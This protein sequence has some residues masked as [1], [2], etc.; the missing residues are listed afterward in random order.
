MSCPATFTRENFSC[1]PILITWLQFSTFLNGIFIGG[2]FADFQQTIPGA[3]LS[4]ASRSTHLHVKFSNAIKN[5]CWISPNK[6]TS[7]SQTTQELDILYPVRR[8]SNT[9]FIYEIPR[10]LIHNLNTLSSL[11]TCG[12]SAFASR[13]VICFI[14][15][16]NP[17]LQV[18]N[19]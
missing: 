10:L 4:R 11:E 5:S 9:L 2:L 1:L 12:S 13:K 16:D 18:K 8:S 6:Q 17:F 14:W 15:D 3:T 7:S 19:T